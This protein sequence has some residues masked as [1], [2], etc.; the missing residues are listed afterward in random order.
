MSTMRV[1]MLQVVRPDVRSN[2]SSGNN[3]TRCSKGTRSRTNSVVRPLIEST[4]QRGKNFSPSFGGR[5][6]PSTT[7][8]VFK[9]F[10]LICDCDT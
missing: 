5:M 1:E 9:P 8:P 4:L 10:C 6:L 7:S 3:G 2:F